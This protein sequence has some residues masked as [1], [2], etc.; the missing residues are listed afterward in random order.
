MNDLHDIDRRLRALPLREPAPELDAAVHAQ[1]EASDA[2]LA[3]RLRTLPLA[4]P[5]AGLDRR[6]HAAR[7]RAEHPAWRGHLLAAAGLLAAL[8][9]T[10]LGVALRQAEAGPQTDTA[11]P[12]AGTG[13]HPGGARPVPWVHMVGQRRIDQAPQLQPHAEGLLE[14]RGELRLRTIDMIDPRTGDRVRIE[15]PEYLERQRVLDTF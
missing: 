1:R 2:L 4:A 3:R 12:V 5:S 10:W 9:L 7:R 8:G 15:I 14:R 11:G 6:I 13:T